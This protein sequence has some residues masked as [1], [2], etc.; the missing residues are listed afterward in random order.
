MRRY[1]EIE[2]TATALTPIFHGGDEKTG[3]TPVLRTIMV[4]V[5]NIGEVPIPYI[6]GN[7]IRGKLRR[8][9]MKDFIDS[10]DYEIQNVKL[11]HVLFSGGMLESTEETY[12]SID[13]ELRKKVRELMPPVALFGCAIGNQMIQGI[14]TV[15]HMWPICLEYSAYLPE[16]YWSDRRAKRPIR[17]FTDQSFITRRDD[18]RAERA[19]DEQAVQMKVDYECFV[20][21][22]KFYHRFILQI[23]DELQK[24]C[25]GRIMDLFAMMPYIGGRGSGGDGKVML[26]YDNIPSA[27][28]YMEFLAEKKDEIRQLL[29]ELEARL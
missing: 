12:G 24:S 14:L 6:S 8:M 11:H 17:T 13:L 15:E 1:Y 23:P 26:S 3:S 25:F 18:L 9:T 5:D 27:D 29:Q 21:G 19:E 22:T 2:G 20:P 10:V 4:Y 7:G 16:K 28:L